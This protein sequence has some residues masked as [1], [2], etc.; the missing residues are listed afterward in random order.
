MTP[1]T[2]SRTFPS[3][4]WLLLGG[5][6][7][8]WSA[9]PALGGDCKTTKQDTAQQLLVSQVAAEDDT[10]PGELSVALGEELRYPADRPTWIDAGP[11]LD[12]Q[13]HC[14]PVNSPPSSSAELSRRALTVQLR[15]AAET[16]LETLFDSPDAPDVIPLADDWI[17]ERI[18]DSRSYEG[19]V[20]SGDEVLYEAAAELRF[21]TADRRWLQAQWDAHR[22]SQRMISLGAMTA[23]GTV[24]LL[25]ATAGLSIIARRV[26]R[27]P[28]PRVDESA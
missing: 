10:P 17:A 19:E 23:G 4:A 20:Y 16:Y 12:G 5:G 22:V 26:E 2:S 6:L 8:G 9:T 1:R 3:I 15:A 21:T 11:E 25:M 27:H 7:L 13:V 14:W 28:R 18:A 24:L